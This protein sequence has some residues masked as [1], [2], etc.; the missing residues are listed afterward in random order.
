MLHETTG[1]LMVKLF[2]IFINFKRHHSSFQCLGMNADNLFVAKSHYLFA[3]DL[4]FNLHMYVSL[5]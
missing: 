1:G 2:C 5:W 4:K 3:W